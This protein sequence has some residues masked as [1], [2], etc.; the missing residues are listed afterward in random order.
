MLE[1]E[2]GFDLLGAENE[3]GKF[4]GLSNDW[5]FRIIKHVGNYGEVFER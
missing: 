5:A 1:V 3:F 4:L 2:P